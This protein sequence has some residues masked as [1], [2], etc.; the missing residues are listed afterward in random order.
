MATL[1][2]HDIFV[3]FIGKAV[4]RDA[5]DELARENRNGYVIYISRYLDKSH[6]QELF[7][8]TDSLK[9][10]WEHSGVDFN[11][12]LSLDGDIITKGC[13]DKYRESGGGHGRPVVHVLTPTQQ[14]LRVAQRIMNY[15]TERS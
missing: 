9:E 2:E 11:L 15:I 6:Y 10:K 14:E 8:V 7:G 4:N 5:F 13:L 3:P 1:S 12:L